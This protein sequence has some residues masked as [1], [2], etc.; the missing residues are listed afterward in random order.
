VS[1]L[2][3]FSE[4]PFDI[5]RRTAVS[6]LAGGGLILVFLM[7]TREEDW[8]TLLGI[9]YGFGLLVTFMFSLPLFWAFWQNGFSA[10]W[11]L[12]AIVPAFWQATGILEVIISAILGIL[13]PWPIMTLTLFVNLIRRRLDENRARTKSDA[14]PGL[15]L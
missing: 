9:G 12:P 6:L 15:H 2:R 13:L 7:M 5:A 11:Y 10:T 14:L 4:W 3:D 8:L 1:A